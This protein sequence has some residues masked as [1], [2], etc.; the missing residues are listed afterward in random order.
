MKPPIQFILSAALALIFNSY[1]IGETRLT[2]QDFADVNIALVD[3]HI[4]PRYARLADALTA[5][6]VSASDYCSA[7]SDSDPGT[8][9]E[10]YHQAMDAWMGIEHVRFGPIELFMRSFRFFFWPQS[11]GKVV[12][13]L[14]ELAG[15]IDQFAENPEQFASTSASVQGLLAAEALVFRTEEFSPGLK[16]GNAGCAMLSAVAGNMSAIANE[17]IADWNGGMMHFRNEVQRPGSDEALYDNH[18]EVTAILFKS[19]HD[20]LQLITEVK[21]RP[22][23]GES[24]DT[25]KPVLAESRPSQRSSRNIAAN[26]E[27]LQALYA[28]ETGAGGLSQLVSMSDT[29]L[30]KLMHRAFSI[31]VKNARSLEQPLEVIATS[32]EQRAQ[33]DKLFLQV[34]ALRQIVRERLASALSMRI[35]FNTLDGD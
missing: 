21:M 8:L 10:T 17:V 27:A 26:L 24:I 9:R 18:Q 30:D 28:G 35:G 23:L 7:N 34:R 25:A 6:E 4:L 19:L 11:R 33:A 3:T 15:R 29:E 12:E 5:F 22:V 2:E 32:T 13:Q 31:T 16:A 14:Q 1:A 20:E